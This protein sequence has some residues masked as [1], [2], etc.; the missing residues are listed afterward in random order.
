[1]FKVQPVKL[2]TR[3]GWFNPY[4]QLNRLDL[5]HEPL[6]VVVFFCFFVVV[7]F[8]IPSLLTFIHKTNLTHK[9]TYKYALTY[10]KHIYI[11]KDI[12]E[13]EVDVPVEVTVGVAVAV[14]VV[15]L[16][17][18]AVDVVDTA[19]V[20]LLAAAIDNMKYSRLPVSRIPRDSLKHFEISVPRHIRV[21]R[22]RKTIN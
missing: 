16:V 22:V 18:D 9:Y 10:I 13:K 4:G 12:L 15:P 11:L 1:M 3:K 6:L 21:E 7:F 5:N 14:D 8:S 17:D 19:E 20:V 2:F